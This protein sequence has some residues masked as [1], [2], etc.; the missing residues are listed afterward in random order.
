MSK[1]LTAVILAGGAGTRMKS[2][3]SK[4][5]H[6]LAGRALLQYPVLASVGAGASRVVVVASP[7]NI[8]DVRACLEEI[9]Q[10]SA[11]AT[12]EV[13]EQSVPRGSGDA[14]KSALS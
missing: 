13:V 7:S 1:S 8:D 11:P 10:V 9:R 6:R 12:L 5:L 3:K 14:A 4:I 2:K